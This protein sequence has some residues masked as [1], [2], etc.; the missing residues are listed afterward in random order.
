[1]VWKVTPD[2]FPLKDTVSEE[3]IIG[4]HW[5]QI[6]RYE[7]LQTPQKVK[8]LDMGVCPHLKK[9]HRFMIALMI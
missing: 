2:I 1:M 5:F 6:L 8:F 3:K 4:T 7:D 9:F